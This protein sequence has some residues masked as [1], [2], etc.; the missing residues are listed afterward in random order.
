MGDD[1]LSKLVSRVGSQWAAQRE[2]FQALSQDEKLMVIDLSHVFCE[3][4]NIP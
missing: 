1:A 3:S 4:Q 2:V